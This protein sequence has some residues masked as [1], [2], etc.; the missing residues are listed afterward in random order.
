MRRGLDLPAHPTGNLDGWGNS[1]ISKSLTQGLNQIR[2][3]DH[4]QLWSEITDL[5]GEQL[6]VLSGAEGD[7]MKSVRRTLDNTETLLPNRTRRAQNT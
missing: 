4:H 1:E 7:H 6:Q 2:I 5:L 3:S